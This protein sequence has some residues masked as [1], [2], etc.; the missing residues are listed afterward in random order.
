VQMITTILDNLDFY[1]LGQFLYITTDPMTEKV[2]GLEIHVRQ[3]N[4]GHVE[5]Q[6]LHWEFHERVHSN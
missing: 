4:Q 5:I 2:G 1:L 3:E 6:E